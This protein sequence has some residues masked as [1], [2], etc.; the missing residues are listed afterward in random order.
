MMK[1]EN[2][3]N[4]EYSPFRRIVIYV[5]GIFGIIFLC[6]GVY[7]PHTTTE[8]NTIWVI[9]TSLSSSVKDMKTTTWSIISRLE[10]IK[11]IIKK[12]DISL[13]W[14]QHGLIT[15]WSHARVILPLQES[16]SQFIESLESLNPEIYAS[17]S[18]I[19]LV[20]TLIQTLYDD[21]SLNIRIFTDGE[22]MFLNTGTLASIKN[23]QITW[24]GVGTRHGGPMLQGYDHEWKP[25]YKLYQNA[26][27][28]S[29]LGVDFFENMKNIPWVTTIL[30]EDEEILPNFEREK[31][32]FFKS[33]N[34][35]LALWGFLLLIALFIAP[36]SYKKYAYK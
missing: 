9:D 26:P 15:F 18:Q 23:K 20:F 1:S 5:L 33:K 3:Y 4:F 31:K 12:D 24:Y 6:I 17:A 8:Q 19:E 35:F 27:A 29:T 34:M 22:N 36:V 13:I 30:L 16:V 32:E 11:N 2:C 14:W 10:F 7:S 25:R 21:M 28:I